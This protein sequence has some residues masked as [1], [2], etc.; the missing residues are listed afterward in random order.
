MVERSLQTQGFRK[1]CHYDKTER[2]SPHLSEEEELR[3]NC[4]V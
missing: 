4:V 3:E 2:L 1:P